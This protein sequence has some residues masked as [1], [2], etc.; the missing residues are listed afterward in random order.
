MLY[1][2]LVMSKKCII[3]CL[4]LKFCVA[5]KKLK[6]DHNYFLWN[7]YKYGCQKIKK[8]EALS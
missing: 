3:Q 7:K 1:Y 4:A 5:N 2:S 8:N 6:T